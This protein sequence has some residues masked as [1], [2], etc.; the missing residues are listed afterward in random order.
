MTESTDKLEELSQ[1][2]TLVE[3]LNNDQVSAI[4]A[5]FE[6]RGGKLEDAGGFE[7]FLHSQ[8]V[9][10]PD[11]CGAT[12][13]TYFNEEWDQVKFTIR[14][15]NKD[16]ISGVLKYIRKNGFVGKENFSVVLKQFGIDCPENSVDGFCLEFYREYN[17]KDQWSRACIAIQKAA[18]NSV[19]DIAGKVFRF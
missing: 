3:K 15:L 4:L 5:Y 12:F 16:Q 2:R 1:L 19:K 13:F 7:Q 14:N 8:K 18:V 17:D 10:C 11:Y 9:E 6:E